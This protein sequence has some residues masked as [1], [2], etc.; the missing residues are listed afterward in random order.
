MSAN[1]QDDMEIIA[2]LL[3]RRVGERSLRALAVVAIADDDA[4]DGCVCEIAC[5]PGAET[6]LRGA[7][8]TAV[9]MVREPQVL[10]LSGVAR[11]LSAEAQ[12]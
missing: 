10:R 4:I 9:G 11:T 1:W 3:K 8:A 7:L 2:E 12:S 6:E 5:A